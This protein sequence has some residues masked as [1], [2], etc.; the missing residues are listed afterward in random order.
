VAAALAA[1]ALGLA[2]C[3]S[4]SNSKGGTTASGSHA[5]GDIVPGKNGGTLQV[6]SNGDVDYIDPGAAYYQFSFILDYATQRPLFSYKADDASKAVPDLAASEAKISNGGKTV[7]IAIRKGVKFSPPVSREV[8]SSDVK[9]A[10]E[11]GFNPH[12]A[13]GY[14]GAYFGDVEGAAKAKGGAISGIQT[15]D[16]QTI[17]FKLTKPNAALVI[18]ALS[19]PISAP[20][21]KSY[22]A[23]YDAM[24]TPNQY[25]LHQVA[26]GPYMI[27][28][29]SAGDTI[30][31]KPGRQIT[32]V[33]NPNWDRST[34]YKPAYLD[35]IIFNEGNSD[36]VSTARRILVGQSMVNGQADFNVPPIILKQLSKGPQ[37]GQLTVGPET[38]R[39]RYVSLNTTIKPFDNVNVRKAVTAGMNRDAMRLALGGP[40]SGDVPTHF[41][42]AVIPGYEQAGGAKGPGFDFLAKPAGD[43]AL[44]ASYMKKAGYASGKYTGNETFQMVSDNVGPTKDAAQVAQ[45]SLTK[46]G[47]KVHLVQVT[48][49]SM[50]TKFCNVPA[51]KVAI[52]PST[53]WAKDFPDPASMLGPTFNGK[54]IIPTNNSNWPQLNDASINA[55]MDA[56]DPIIDPAKRAAAWGA[57]DKQITAQAPG[58]PW[59]WDRTAGISSKNVNAVLNKFNASWDLTYTSLK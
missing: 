12:V 29:N 1:G 56:A 30:G 44:A 33:R 45:A 9:Y 36:A 53:G 43:A 42:P 21:P 40:L 17:V 14:V 5:T 19:L 39:V 27:E 23:K 13:N 49:D 35:K 8:T 10:I 34:D 37:S 54:N 47:F 46:L 58:V 26:T 22:A 57:I 41:L 18:G 2:A 4:S 24:K 20:V 50:Y 31:Y 32:L 52:C 51:Q 25:G 3:G 16:P 15:P 11:R 38:G 7:T 28:N 55:A 48:H 59:L 6:M